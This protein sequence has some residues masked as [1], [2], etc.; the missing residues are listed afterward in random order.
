[1]RLPKA[2]SGLGQGPPA[3]ACGKSAPGLRT[4]SAKTPPPGQDRPRK[5]Q[6]LPVD[7]PVPLGQHR[8]MLG[9]TQKPILPHPRSAEQRRARKNQIPMCSLR[10]LTAASFVRNRITR[11]IYEYEDEFVQ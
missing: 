2:V 8:A 11:P 1:V 3:P 4:P 6:K 10:S 7:I 5:R 9:E